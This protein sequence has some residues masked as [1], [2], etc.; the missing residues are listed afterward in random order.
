VLLVGDIDRGGIFA[1]MLGTLWLLEP[2]ERRLVRGLIVNKFRGELSLFQEGVR[3]LEERGKVPV[4]G[5]VPY[6]PGLNLPEEDAATLHHEPAA[7][8][9]SIDI[10]VIHLPH[11]ANF[12]DFAPVSAEPGV[13]LR[14]VDTP[15]ALG[16][17]QALILPGTKSTIADLD[18]LRKTGLAESILRFVESG[19]HVAGICGGY[20]MLGTS[21]SD[22]MLVESNVDQVP[23]LGLLPLATE[24]AGRKSTY[25]AKLRVLAGPE[26]MTGLEGEILSAYEIHMGVT[27]STSPLFEITERNGQPTRV[28]EG[29]CSPDGSVWG[30]YLH[31][32]FA[33]DAFRHAWLRSLGW[34]GPGDHES[35]QLLERSLERLAD[36]VEAA[37]DMDRLDKI[38]WG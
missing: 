11:I 23:G 25:Q 34:Q 18:W 6:I 12:D 14:Y 13:L 8:S 27:T 30:C 3:I 37:L 24:F 22:P 26:W 16:Q 29:A 10:A 9:A 36:E 15:A 28:R 20:Q 4:L 31:G 19:G 35:S 1:Q 5:V 32:L 21:I 2:D 7:S 38:I 33:N 17:P